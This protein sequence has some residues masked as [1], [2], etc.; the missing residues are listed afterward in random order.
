[1]PFN[2]ITKYSLN[3][4]IYLICGVKKLIQYKSLSC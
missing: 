2:G 4:R 1:M 3:T